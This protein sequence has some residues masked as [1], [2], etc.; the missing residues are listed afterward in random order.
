MPFCM[1]LILILKVS[2]QQVKLAVSSLNCGHNRLHTV[3][4]ARV[5]VHVAIFW[6]VL[7]VFNVPVTV[8]TL[9]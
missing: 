8:Y 1:S 7:L 5:S 3:T 6:P 9:H 4:T 2:S